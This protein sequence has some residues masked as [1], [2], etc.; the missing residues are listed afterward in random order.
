MD[1]LIVPAHSKELSA[2]LADLSGVE[3]DV[4]QQCQ[5]CAAGCPAAYAMDYTPAQLLHAVQLGLR[6]LVLGSGTIWLCVSCQTCVARCPQNVDIAGL[7]D[8]LRAMAL[9]S[10]RP[11][12]GRKGP[13][14]YRASLNNIR[15]F[16]H[17]YELGLAAQLEL[18][19]LELRRDP[20][21]I[22]GTSFPRPRPKAAPYDSS[23]PAFYR[24]LSLLQGGISKRRGEILKGNTRELVDQ[25]FELLLKEEVLKAARK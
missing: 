16:G 11:S 5:K 23:L 8:A 2:L 4:C 20:T 12:G 21:R 7:M 19:P 22:T 3:A 17:L 18:P 15:T 1:K 25:L 10:R 6:D 14:F 9:R 13:A 24:I